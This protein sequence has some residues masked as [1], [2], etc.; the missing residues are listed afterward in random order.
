MKKLIRSLT[1]FALCA[2]LAL[3][4]PTAGA[5]ELT[6]PEGAPLTVLIAV[7]LPNGTLSYLPVTPV[8]NTLG[9]TVYWVDESMLSDDEIALLATAQLQLVSET[10]ELYAELP[11]ESSGFAG[12]IDTRL[13]I[14]SDAIPGGSLTIVPA[15]YGA[16]TDGEEADSVLYQY[17]F[18]T[19]APSEP[20]QPEEPVVEP[21][22]PE[23]PAVEPEQPEEP[24]VEPEQPEE[25]VVEPEQP[26]EPVVEPEQPEEPAV[27]PEQPEEPVV[28]PE[29]PEEPVVEPEQ[30]TI[31]SY[32]IAAFDGAMWFN[33]ANTWDI[34]E[35]PNADDVMTVNDYTIDGE[36]LLWYFVTDYRTQNEY[37]ADRAGTDGRTCR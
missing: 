2:V 3:A 35:A 33:S 23:E 34:A 1:A 19:P 30:P 28:E 31:P 29:Q 20:E 26:E 15:E 18:E 24:A 4:V 5:Q 12:A 9:S 6:T 36:G 16:P 17:G 10:G 21:E 8:T 32:V 27:E 13:D 37:A 22:Q 25:P 14:M 7:T 11:L